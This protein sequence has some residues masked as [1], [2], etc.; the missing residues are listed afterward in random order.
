MRLHPSCILHSHCRGASTAWA[1]GVPTGPPVQGLWAAAF[2]A[3][4]WRE[5]SGA[6][7]CSRGGRWALQKFAACKQASLE[8]GGMCSS[9][10]R[11]GL[12]Q[13]YQNCQSRSGWWTLDQGEKGLSGWGKFHQVEN[14][15]NIHL[16][17]FWKG[18]K[19]YLCIIRRQEA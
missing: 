18:K 13:P 19:K 8:A 6:G 14:G 4:A 11:E 5:T 7:E 17:S 10:F 16:L 1:E 2:Q 12:A 15:W 3:E 9:S